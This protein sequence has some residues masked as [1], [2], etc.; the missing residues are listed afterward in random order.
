M[1][2]LD[3][4]SIPISKDMEV[5][6]SV[7]SAWKSAL[8]SMGKLIIG[9]PQAANSGPELLALSSWHLYPDLF[10]PAYSS[11]VVRFHDL[12]VSSGGMLTVGLE[13]GEGKSSCGLSWLLS[14]AH[15]N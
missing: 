5:H 6:S 14:L 1:L 12:L 15:I 10:L 2:I 8:E 11:E 13:S 9:M 3:N 7:L 4:I